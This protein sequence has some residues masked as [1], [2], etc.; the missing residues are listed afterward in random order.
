MNY[1]VM[2]VLVSVSTLLIFYL[3]TYARKKTQT[4]AEKGFQNHIGGC[5]I[6]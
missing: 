5:T 6:I 1:D 2:I 3:K 4:K